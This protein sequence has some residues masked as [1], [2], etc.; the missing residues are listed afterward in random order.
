VAYGESEIPPQ[1]RGIAN[2]GEAL[3]LNDAHTCVDGTEVSGFRKDQQGV[4]FNFGKFRQLL[5]KL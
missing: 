4:Y 1:L 2:L 5:H 3:G